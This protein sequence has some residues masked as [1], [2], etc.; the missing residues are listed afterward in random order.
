MLCCVQVSILKNYYSKNMKKKFCLLWHRGS[1]LASIIKVTLRQAPLVLDGWLVRGLTPGAGNLYNQPLRSTQPGHPCVSRH[2]VY[3]PKSG[4]ALQLGKQSQVWFMCGW[5]VKLCD[6]LA[7]TGHIW[8]HYR[9]VHRALYRSILHF[10]GVLLLS[11]YLHQRED[12]RRLH[13]VCSHGRQRRQRC[14]D[15]NRGTFASV[16]S[17]CTDRQYSSLCHGYMWNNIIMKYFC[18]NF[19]VSFH[20]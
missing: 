15:C 5:Q 1:A 9:C 7:N 16:H 17:I 3:Q 2:N 18:N 11:Q 8:A 4:D 13:P 14:D 6:S 12:T 19:S 10:V 20:M